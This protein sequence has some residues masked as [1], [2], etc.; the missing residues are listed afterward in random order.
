[1]RDLVFPDDDLFF[2]DL[3]RVQLE[4]E[5]RGR[6][7]DFWNIF[8]E[9]TDFKLS[10]FTQ[11]SVIF[12]AKNSWWHWLSRKLPNYVEYLWKSKKNSD[13]HIV[14]VRN[15]EVKRYSIPRLVIEGTAFYYRYPNYRQEKITN[16]S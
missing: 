13:H 9:K 5:I 1:V 16:L 7:Y 10:I 11:I 2:Q 8:A 15:W 14:L 3:H 4:G 6:C 12:F